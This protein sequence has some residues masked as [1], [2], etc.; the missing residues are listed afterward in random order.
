[1]L[2]YMEIFP[3]YPLC[4][5]WWCEF[6]VLSLHLDMNVAHKNMTWGDRSLDIFK[7]NLMVIKSFKFAYFYT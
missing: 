7:K 6:M 5:L 2:G 3:E 1:M 4:H